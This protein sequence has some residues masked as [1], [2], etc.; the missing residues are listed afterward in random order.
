MRVNKKRVYLIMSLAP[1]KF[2]QKNY[3]IKTSTGTAS[4]R[5]DVA[6]SLPAALYKTKQANII[7]RNYFS[8]RSYGFI[9]ARKASDIT[10]AARVSAALNR[11]AG[12]RSAFRVGEFWQNPTF[13]NAQI[14]QQ[15]GSAWE[16][17]GNF[18]GTSVSALGM[19]NQMGVSFNSKSKAPDETPN[20]RGDVVDNA[21][22]GLAEV[23]SGST[24]IS[25]AIAKMENCENSTTL[26]NAIASANEQLSSIASNKASLEQLTSDNSD[27]L[28]GL[29]GKK[30]QLEQNMSKLKETQG[31]QKSV[32]S[33]TQKQLGDAQK[34]EEKADNAVKGKSQVYDKAVNDYKTAQNNTKTAQTGVSNAETLLSGAKAELAQAKLALLPNGEPD[35][36]KITQAQ[37]KV[38]EAEG[39]LTEAKNKLTEAKTKEE[40]ANTAKQQAAN[41]LSDAKG[42]SAEQ[43]KAVMDAMAEVSKQKG[44]LDRVTAQLEQT[45]AQLKPME[46]A[47]ADTKSQM[48]VL[49]AQSGLLAKSKTDEKELQKAIEKHNKQ[50]AKFE[51]AESKEAVKL[52]TDSNDGKVLTKRKSDTDAIAGMLSRTGTPGTGKYTGNTYYKYTNPQTG[53]T[54]YYQKKGNT[55]TPITE[56]MYNLATS[57]IRLQDTPIDSVDYTFNKATGGRNTQIKVIT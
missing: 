54:F 2:E 24:D 13:Q 7:G 12:Q 34:A 1:L 4:G 35:T 21:M 47:L 27:K 40:Q 56:N 6:N 44:Q 25:N 52:G 38:T 29:E 50:L 49:N 16:S 28:V 19:L 53:N 48:D 9:S 14:Y 3:N 43:R 8:Q 51:A 18:L 33:S 41:D 17:F 10:S 5:A 39:K 31:E 46:D 23:P 30:G 20:T 36:E 26:R 45:E 55:A 22:N 32:V 37:A 11:S 57:G 42:V 15:Q